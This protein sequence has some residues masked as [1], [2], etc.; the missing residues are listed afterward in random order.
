M[1][2]D[3]KDILDVCKK[4]YI[5]FLSDKILGNIINV[6][7]AI[8]GDVVECG[9]QNDNKES[10]LTMTIKACD[11]M[12]NKTKNFYV[13]D[14]NEDEINAL[15]H[16]RIIRGV[17][18]RLYPHKISLLYLLA[19]DYENIK[20]NLEN[21]YD[22]VS[23]GGIIIIKNY[24]IREE[25]KKAV[26]EFLNN[27]RS[28]QLDHSGIYFTKPKSNLTFL[29]FSNTGFSNPERIIYQARK[30]NMFDDI[31]HMSEKDIPDFIN[32]HQDFI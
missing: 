7:H 24:V 1:S 2:E 28:I 14:T 10:I 8:D 21:F 22:R 4:M 31:V 20:D 15:A 32:L 19:H 11:M 26:D 3:F 23:E 17:K 9:I 6:I 29:T 13:Y 30:M 16:S 18:D 25:C 27:H 5:S 12:G